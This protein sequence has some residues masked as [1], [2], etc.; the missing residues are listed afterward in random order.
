MKI[1]IVLKDDILEEAIRLTKIKDKTALIHT[2]LEALIQNYSKK[3]LIEFKGINK[4]VN[5]NSFFKKH[6]AIE[7]KNSGISAAKL[8]RKIRDNE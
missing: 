4:N 6:T 1:T 8:I 7:P 5:W 2:G 3:R